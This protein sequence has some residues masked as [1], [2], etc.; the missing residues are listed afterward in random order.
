LPPEVSW[1]DKKKDLAPGAAV[2]RP[3]FTQEIA[4]FNKRACMGKNERFAAERRSPGAR[5]E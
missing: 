1:I 3:P 4:R 2:G 5:P